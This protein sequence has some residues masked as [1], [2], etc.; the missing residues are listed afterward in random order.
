MAAE[1]VLGPF[2]RLYESILVGR[3][4][5]KDGVRGFVKHGPFLVRRAGQH[6]RPGSRTAGS[7][8]MCTAGTAGTT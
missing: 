2:W 1:E 8:G 3:M 7:P 6:S 5:E 4:V